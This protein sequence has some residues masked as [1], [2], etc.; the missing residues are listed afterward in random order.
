[1]PGYRLIRELVDEEF[2]Q[3]L[4]EGRDVQ[5]VEELRAAFA[6]A[7]DDAAL[8]NVIWEKLRNLPMAFR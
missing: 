6:S 5:K 2:T 3:S 8:L 1:M 7:G 4:E